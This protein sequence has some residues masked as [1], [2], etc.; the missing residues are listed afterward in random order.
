[1]KKKI[2]VD[3]TMTGIRFDKA[4]T[5]TLSNRTRSQLQN[6]IKSGRITVNGTVRTPHYLLKGGDCIE[7]HD[8]PRLSAD[9]LPLPPLNVIASCADYVVVNK[10]SGMIVHPSKVHPQ[11]DTLV[12]AV[13]KKYPEIAKVGDDPQRP[14]IV[15]RLDKDASGVM[16]VARTQDSFED[17]K[18]Q[19]K[20]RVVYKEYLIVTYGSMQPLEGTIRRPIARSV[21]QHTRFAAKSDDS[22]KEAITEYWT[23]DS[24]NKFSLIRVH[25]L[26]GRTHQIRVHF[27]SKG[28][29]LVGDP[30]YRLKTGKFIH[31]SRLMLHARVLSFHD[32]KDISQEYTCLPDEQFLSIL[33]DCL[34]H[35]YT[36]DIKGMVR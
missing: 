35:A 28:N 36:L 22:G 31:S 4:L 18:R 29:S 34:P 24:S 16:V 33:Y 12:D 7:I 3:E 15:H 26:T 10:P 21:R 32:Q 17:L 14:G 23:V 27:H 5:Q 6:D 13:L 19:F 2:T 8:T 20:T 25:P 11:P 30:I 9:V 1:M